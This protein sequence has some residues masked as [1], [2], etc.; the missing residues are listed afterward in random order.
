MRKIQKRYYILIFVAIVAF[1][2]IIRD[3]STSSSFEIIKNPTVYAPEAENVVIDENEYS[4]YMVNINTG[5]VPELSILPGIGEKTA[6]KI[7][8]YRTKY[9]RFEV[10]EDILKVPGIG[11]KTFEDIKDNITVE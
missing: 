10:I 2:A 4:G 7:I 5:S 9:G 1:G 8:E 6:E 11:D 3:I